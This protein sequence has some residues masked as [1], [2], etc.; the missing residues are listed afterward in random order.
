M[1]VG[2]CALVLA[3]VSASAARAQN[4]TAGGIISTAAG[5]G[6]NASAGA[7]GLATT[8]PIGGPL[9]VA[10]DRTGNIYLIDRFHNQVDVVN[11]QAAA[12]T[13]AGVTIQPANTA[14]IVGATGSCGSVGAI[15]DGGPA[16]DA[17]LCG[18]SSLA[19]D[20]KGIF[21]SSTVATP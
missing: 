1:R 14:V 2:L 3:I 10:L 9:S 17:L 12:I 11:E 6:V 5:N 16:I 13:I 15:G 21:T 20:A 7:G 18:P 19:I 8:T 4:I